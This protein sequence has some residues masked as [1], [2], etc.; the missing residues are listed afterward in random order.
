M[1]SQTSGVVY[2]QDNE[3]MACTIGGAAPKGGGGPRKGLGKEAGDGMNGDGNAIKNHAPLP[4]GSRL[5]Q[6]HTKG[7]RADAR[8]GLR[9]VIRYMSQMMQFD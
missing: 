5:H 4:V 2:T 3:F 8:S 7:L 1:C 6:T 9:R